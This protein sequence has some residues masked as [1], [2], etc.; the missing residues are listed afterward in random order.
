V[1][2]QDSDAAVVVAELCQVL[3]SLS[4]SAVQRLLNELRS[5]NRA[6]L[7]GARRWARWY[8]VTNPIGP[9][10][11]PAREGSSEAGS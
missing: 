7:L 1:D 4:E 9:S 6:R 2:D 3:P 8:V 5:E 11:N 10:V